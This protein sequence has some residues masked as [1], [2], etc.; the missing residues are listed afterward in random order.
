[1]EKCFIA[2][3]K[4]F[5][6]IEIKL[7]KFEIQTQNFES[8]EEIIKMNTLRRASWSIEN[9]VRGRFSSLS[10]LTFGTFGFLYLGPAMKK[11]SMKKI[12]RHI[13]HSHNRFKTHKLF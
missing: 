11:N 8:N 3:W 1:M 7:W 9:A 6:L 4:W 2:N 5:L 10:P 13:L 12:I